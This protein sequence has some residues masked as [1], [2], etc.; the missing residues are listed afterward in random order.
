MGRGFFNEYLQ[1]LSAV[2]TAEPLTFACWFKQGNLG[3]AN[4]IMSVGDDDYD[5]WSLTTGVDNKLTFRQHESNLI[6]RNVTTTTTLS[7][8]LVWHH[9]CGVQR[10]QSTTMSVYLNGG[11]KATGN[12]DV[13]VSGVDRTRIASRSLS[14]ADAAANVRMA[15]VAIYNI[16]L[17]D[18]EV[19]ILA[20]GYSPLLVRPQNL[21]FYVPLIRDNDKDLVGGLTLTLGGTPTIAVHPPMIYIAPPYLIHGEAPYVTP[22]YGPLIQVV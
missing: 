4:N 20:L 8:A 2:V 6:F 10:A 1:V 16:D 9:A 14:G 18:T 17:T 7:D 11:G 15:E 3:D 21:V 22:P 5:E 19:E 12:N 13:D